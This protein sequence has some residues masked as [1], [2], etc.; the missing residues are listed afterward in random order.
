[1]HVHEYNVFYSKIEVVLVNKLSYSIVCVDKIIFQFSARFCEGSA[2]VASKGFQKPA[3][4]VF[5][6]QT[7]P[8]LMSFATFL[9]AHTIELTL[10]SPNLGTSH[11]K[12]HA[13]V[14]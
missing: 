4:N 12:M 6:S 14:K 2:I 1:M 5:Q 10:V 9:Q 11:L 8:V 3:G 7:P 13:S